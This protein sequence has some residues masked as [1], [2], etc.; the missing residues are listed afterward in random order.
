MAR[1]KN[2]GRG[3]LG[4]RAKG[5]PNKVNEPMRRLL[6]N[7]CM[8]NYED[9]C[10]AYE[11]IINP[12]ERAEAWLKAAAFVVPKPLAVDLT[13]RGKTLDFKSELDEM[14]EEK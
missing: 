8:E 12:K 7:F 3:R 13:T 11:K 4:G 10:A 6:E 14:A 2:D 1:P 9:F 5:T